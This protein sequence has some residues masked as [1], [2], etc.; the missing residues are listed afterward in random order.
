MLGPGAVMMLCGLILGATGA[1]LHLI[2]FIVRLEL[3]GL[4]AGLAVSVA[5]TLVTLLV[6]GGDTRK[7]E[8]MLFLWLFYLIP[9]VGI[10]LFIQ[11]M[12]S[13]CEKQTV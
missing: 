5:S 7:P 13:R 12:I 2:K 11:F 6:F 3:N 1:V 4:L 9:A 8:I 10:Y